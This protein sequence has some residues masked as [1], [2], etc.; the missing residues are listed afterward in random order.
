MTSYSHGH[1]AMVRGILGLSIGP[2]WS[3]HGLLQDL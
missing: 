1:H 2:V 3:M